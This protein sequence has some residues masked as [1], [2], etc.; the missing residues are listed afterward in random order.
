MELSDWTLFLCAVVT[1]D[2]VANIAIWAEKHRIETHLR[3]IYTAMRESQA[4]VVEHAKKAIDAQ[5]KADPA[6]PS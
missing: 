3:G 4:Q 1:I 5:F 2:A 6:D